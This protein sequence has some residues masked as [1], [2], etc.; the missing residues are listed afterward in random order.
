MT[1]ATNYDHLVKLILWHRNNKKEHKNE[2]IITEKWQ[3]QCRE[4]EFP[5]KSYVNPQSSVHS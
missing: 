2:R 3:L 5:K 4:K 1:S